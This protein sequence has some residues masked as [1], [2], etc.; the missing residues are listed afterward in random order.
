MNT[1]NFQITN[2]KE[3]LR[4][5]LFREQGYD[6]KSDKYKICTYLHYY[7]NETYPF[8][9]GSGTMQRAFTFL[10]HDR[11]NNW[12]N[13]V[14]DIN[15]VKVIIY[16]FNITKYEAKCLEQDL[17]SKY[18][19]FNCLCNIRISN[20]KFIKYK[21]DKDVDKTNWACFDLRGNHIKTFRTIKEAADEYLTIE[22]KIRICAKK[23]KA[24]RGIIKWVKI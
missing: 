11:N 15:K 22:N 19:E 14:K 6:Y 21:I 8:Y 13:K 18:S 1:F 10:K 23:N 5:R 7:N 4:E 3:S 12:V 9:I 24:F 17:I 20:K 16:R 2:K